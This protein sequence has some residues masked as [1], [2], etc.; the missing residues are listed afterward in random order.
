M[1]RLFKVGDKVRW[2]KVVIDANPDRIT[3]NE[4]EGQ[5][6]ATR[7]ADNYDCVPWQYVFTNGYNAREARFV[8]GSKVFGMD[9]HEN[10]RAKIRSTLIYHREEFVGRLNYLLDLYGHVDTATS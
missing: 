2:F 10:L 7:G 6:V 9:D 3:V 1:N 8:D 5:V 4:Y